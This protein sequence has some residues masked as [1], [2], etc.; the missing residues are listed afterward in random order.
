VGL[1][2][3]SAPLDTPA[4]LD[5]IVA[6]A[7]A[8][9]FTGLGLGGCGLSPASAPALA[10]LLGGGSL[11]SLFVQNSNAPLLDA[12][13]ALVLA[14]ALRANCTLDELSLMDTALWHDRAA[15]ATLLG[16]ITAHCSLRS[17]SFYRNTIGDAQDAAGAALGA[18]VAANAPALLLLSL[19][20]CGLE[21]AALGLLV[22]ALPRNTHLRILRL[23]DVTASAAFLRNRLLPA[24]RANTSL[25]LLEITV[26][27]EG[28][29]A[30]RE[31][32]EIVNSRAA[33]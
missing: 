22:D 5:A 30:A 18:L 21:E 25:T 24:V 33:R 7:L 20:D 4:A 28:E 9:R 32:Q 19:R 12:A 23:G 11:R 13:A 26:T 2:L 14:D 15:A 8:K 16:A 6:V 10:R 17:V 29:S 1:S 27:G 31:A 3:I